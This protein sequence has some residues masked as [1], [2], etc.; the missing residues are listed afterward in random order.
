L[1]E[2]VWPRERVVDH[3]ETPV[4][5]PFVDALPDGV[6]RVSLPTPFHVGRVNCYVL[7]DPP[8]TVIDPG[9][10]QAASL[11]QLA[12]ALT[13]Q[14]LG[15]GDVEQ[16][17]V[18]H[19][20][21]DHFGAAAALAARA[22]TRIVCGLAERAS[23]LGPRD[24]ERTRALLVALGV[25]AATARSLMAVTG[26]AVQ[27]LVGWAPAG[28]VVGVRDGERLHAGGRQFVCLVSPGHAAGHLSLWD[29]ADS[30]LFSGDHLLARIIPGPSLERDDGAGSCRSLID[31]LDGLARFAAFDPAVVLPGHGLAFTQVAVL[32][33]RL[34]AHSR[35]RA[36]D[37]AALLRERPATPFELARRLQW[38]PE[39]WRLLG[40]LA[41]VQGH[42]DLLQASGRVDPVISGGVVHYRLRD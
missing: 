36:D 42:L 4:L 31:Y 30:I 15:F 1:F 7:V 20:H 41:H 37:I 8:V 26:A 32:Q 40:G 39:G 29:P 17:V 14:G 10:L 23:L 24:P 6:V 21:P 22:R 19:A 25:P 12:D 18:T 11:R 28:V 38:Q 16:I 3:T 13:R 34:R 35:Q 5:P 2:L 9:I 27:R 33:A